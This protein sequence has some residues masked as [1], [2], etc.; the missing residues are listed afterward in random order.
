M[1]VSFI[2]FVVIKMAILHVYPDLGIN[3]LF[4]F[5]LL[6][7]DFSHV[8]LMCYDV[9]LVYV[10]TVVYTTHC[11]CFCTSSVYFVI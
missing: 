11:L 4:L 3:N 7:L 1:D 6:Y 10:Y 9:R 8:S 5:I 2:D